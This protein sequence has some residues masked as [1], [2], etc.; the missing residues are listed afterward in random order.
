MH[1]IHLHPIVHIYTIHQ[2][3]DG[4]SDNSDSGHSTID[5]AQSMNVTFTIT[6]QDADILKEHLDDFQLWQRYLNSSHLA[7]HLTRRPVRY[8]VLHLYIYSLDSY[9]E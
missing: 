9:E 7:P 6:H 5:T 4:S 1:Y 8:S 2:Q 3:H